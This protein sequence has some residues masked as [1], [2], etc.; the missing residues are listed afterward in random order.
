MTMRR[1]IAFQALAGLLAATWLGAQQLTLPNRDGSVKFAVI[2][3]NGDGDSE[4]YEVG[5][6]M[7]KVHDTFKF[8]F[9]IMLGDNMYGSQRPRDFVKKFETPYKVLLE[10]KVD[11]YA[12][13][14]NHDE[15][16]NRFYEP[17]NMKG[18]RYYAYEKGNAHF[19]VLDTSY[20]D[21]PQIEWLE[22]ELKAS[23]DEWK[24]V[25]FHHPLYSSG[26][27][28]GSEADLQKVLE[29]LFVKY[30]VNVVFQGHDHIYERVK[31]QK[32]IYYFVEGASGKL[33]KG[34]L[35]KTGLT[36]AGYDQDQSFMLIEIDDD[37]MHFQAISRTGKTLDSGT[38]T[39]QEPA[40]KPTA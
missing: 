28:H 27:R 12:S 8:E 7:T 37:T 10:R 5:A 29:P 22:R 36:A 34:D 24:I 40:K 23:T 21:R 6:V 38:I 18:E 4:Q 32:G 25:Y 31:P 1:H 9:V 13:L 17:W 20:L 26:G 19:F 39:R 30:G 11:F 16:E 33:R 15:P 2:G 35:E 3:D 14:G